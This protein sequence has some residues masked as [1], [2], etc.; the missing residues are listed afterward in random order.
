MKWI[1]DWWWARQ[2]KVDLQILWPACKRVAPTLD[3]AKH[4]FMVHAIS[5]PAWVRHYGEGLWEAVN[6]LS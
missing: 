6:E 1:R 2:R 3:Q 5:D 4:A